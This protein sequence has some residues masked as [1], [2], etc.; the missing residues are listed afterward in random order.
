MGK[1]SQARVREAAEDL[2]Q[3]RY[4]V[5]TFPT[6]SDGGRD[7]RDW[8]LSG[9]R[10]TA[11]AAKAVE[12]TK[13]QPTSKKVSNIQSQ[14]A[15]SAKPSAIECIPQHS[16]ETH[17][18]LA[19]ELRDVEKQRMQVIQEIKRAGAKGD[20]KKVEE[21]KARRKELGALSNQLE[22]K[23]QQERRKL[24]RLDGDA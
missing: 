17:Q 20:E 7:M 13:K 2:V 16:Y 4:G 9:N 10:V 8:Q 5:G 23:V 22:Y 3:W 11:A 1:I 12:K 24:T 18:V 19:N 14:I 6:A 15:Q 21:L